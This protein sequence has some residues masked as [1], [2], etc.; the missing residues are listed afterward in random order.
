MQ[1]QTIAAILVAFAATNVLA[2][3]VPNP[4]PEVLLAL[5]I[6]IPSSADQI[7]QAV[8]VEAREEN[9][10]ACGSS[11]YPTHFAYYQKNSL[12]SKY[13]YHASS[14]T[15]IQY[16]RETFSLLGIIPLFERTEFDA[17]AE[18]EYD[19]IAIYG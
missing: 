5:I 16:S 17:S 4:V 8:N 9:C 13:I 6:S 19:I 15:D 10:P 3:P 12:D 7:L 1:F 2:A 18:K 14:E 11:G